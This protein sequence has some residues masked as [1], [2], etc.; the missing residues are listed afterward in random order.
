VV[1]V[2]LAGAFFVFF[3]LTMGFMVGIFA[4]TLVASILIWRNSRDGSCSSSSVELAEGLSRADSTAQKER[5]WHSLKFRVLLGI[6][7]AIVG[8][9]VSFL[10]LFHMC[11]LTMP[12]FE[13][14]FLV[15][16]PALCFA[17][18]LLCRRYRYS[19]VI[20]ITILVVA[21]NVGQ[22]YLSWLHHH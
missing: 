22:E 6:I 9:V 14:S 4:G 8:F 3:S 1:W 13:N 18:V 5:H 17:S 19:L 2:V 20:T 11:E 21:W 16:V 12:V 10:A 7:H 15:S